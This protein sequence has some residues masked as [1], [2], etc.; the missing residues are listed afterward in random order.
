MSEPSDKSLSPAGRLFFGLLCGLAGIFPFLAAFDVGPLRQEDINGPP[1]LAAVAGGVFILAGIAVAR[2]EQAQQSVFGHFLLLGII[3]SFAAIGNW[4]AF[5]PGLRECSGGFSGLFLPS[6]HNAGEIECRVAFGIGA[7]MVNGMLLMAFAGVMRRLTG[8][9]LFADLVE[10]FGKA[11]LL[12]SL[13]PI[14]LLLVVMLLGKSFFEGW[15]EYRKTGK[16]PRNE[17]FIAR[18]KKQKPR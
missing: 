12:L 11:L 6:Y 8:P 18:Q 4:I 1:W 14:L 3:G 5:G 15:R 17:A 13:L 7:G 10:K 9:S 16:W 2:G